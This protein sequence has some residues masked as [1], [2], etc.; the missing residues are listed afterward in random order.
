MQEDPPAP[1]A[2]IQQKNSNSIDILV[3]DAVNQDFGVLHLVTP[4]EGGKEGIEDAGFVT[5]VASSSKPATKDADTP[6]QDE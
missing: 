6:A 1:E 3:C 5:W 2:S 4:T